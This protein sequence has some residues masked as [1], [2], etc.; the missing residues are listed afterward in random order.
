M[1]QLLD[2]RPRRVETRFEVAAARLLDTWLAA[3]RM[4][5]SA[6]ELRIAGEFLARLGWRVTEGSGLAVRLTRPD[7]RVEESSREDV[8][9][10]ALR[11]LADLEGRHE[12]LPPAAG[13]GSRT[14]AA[15]FR[16]RPHLVPSLDPPFPRRA[17]A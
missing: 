17:S 5:V 16:P 4:S 13:R 12:A 11:R 9:M 3:R 8:L 2:E 10:L 14:S 1:I 7:G 15:S 6:E